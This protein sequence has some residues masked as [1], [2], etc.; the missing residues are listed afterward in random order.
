VI[1]AVEEKKPLEMCNQCGEEVEKRFPLQTPLG[2]K[3]WKVEFLCPLCWDRRTV[4]QNRAQ[5]RHP[6][7][8]KKHV[9]TKHRS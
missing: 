5:R 9:P 1:E 2:N 8:E 4:K 3:R 6:V 7:K